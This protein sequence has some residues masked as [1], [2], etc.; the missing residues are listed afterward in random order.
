M[1]L[2]HTYV[3]ADDRRYAIGNDDSLDIWEAQHQ[4]NLSNVESAEYT[5]VVRMNT[6]CG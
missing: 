6:L 3:K 1:S 2:C 4:W 5:L